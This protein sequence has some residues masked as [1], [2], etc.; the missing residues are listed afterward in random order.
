M[1]IQLLLALFLG[2]AAIVVLV[3]RTRLDAFIALLIACLVTGVVAGQPLTGIVDSITEGFG[4]TLGSIGIVIGLGVAIGK[5]LEVSGAADAL[6]RAFLGAFGKGREEWAMGTVGS[7]V[8]IPVFC[9]SGYVIMNPL[10]RSIARVKRGGYVALAL[11]LGCGMTL[12]HHLVPPTPGPLAATGILGADLG[13]VI[14][15]GLVFTIILLP[16]VVVYARWVGPTLEDRVIPEVR[17]AVYGRLAP[18]GAGGSSGDLGTDTPHDEGGRDGH[19]PDELADR[20]TVSPTTHLG[21]PPAGAKPHR[22]G[23]FVGSL[24]LVLPLLLIVLN[25]VTAAIDRNQQGALSGE[26]E[27][28]SWTT[29]FAFLG[30]PV[31]ALVIGA[32]LAV[33]LLLPRWTPRSKVQGWLAEAA[34]SAGLILLITGAGGA[35]GQ[36]LR[37]S[38]VGDALAEAIAATALPA[39]LVPFVIATV[40]RVAQGSGT[41]AMITAASVT[42]PLVG[43]L[44]IH[45]VVAVLACTS[46]SMVFSYFNDSYFWVVTRFTGIEGTAALKG[47]SGITTAVWAGSIPLL[48]I[49]N[50][51]LG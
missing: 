26:Y 49:L 40:V 3:L 44:G 33:Y 16:V 35:F 13:M 43:S 22:V 11:A 15:T 7:L 4:A 10:A 38:G 20:Q 51:I 50:L 30:N 5:I 39:F 47:W 12:T 32:I 41:V 14:L 48:V 37:D 29:P 21:E 31:V 9:D 24:P 23:A 8:S 1:D 27:A 19:V 6:A 36:V 42:A 17:E 25:T 46:G 45:P 34:A 2:I 18:V 28:S